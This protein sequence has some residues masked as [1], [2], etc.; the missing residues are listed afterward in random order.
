MTSRRLPMEPAVAARSST[1]PISSE[2]NLLQ[3]ASYLGSIVGRR[4]EGVTDVN[5]AAAVV[6][7]GGTPRVGAVR[8]RR[9]PGR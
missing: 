2:N 5:L 3:G 9:P 7:D 1:K 4:D 8:R 6:E